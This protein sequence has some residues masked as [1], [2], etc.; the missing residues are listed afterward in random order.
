[1][2]LDISTFKMPAWLDSVEET[3]PEP[4]QAQQYDDF[5]MRAPSPFERRFWGVSDRLYFDTSRSDRFYQFD[6]T[7]GARALLPVSAPDL[8]PQSQS[9]ADAFVLTVETELFAATYKP[10]SHQAGTTISPTCHYSPHY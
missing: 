3:A 4:V 7:F 10:L 8:E 9:G 6:V 1:M 2:C 5:E